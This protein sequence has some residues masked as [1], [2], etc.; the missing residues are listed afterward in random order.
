MG[1]GLYT[2]VQAVV[3]NAFGLKIT[4]ILNTATRTDKV[5]NASPTAAS[6]A[7]DMNGMAAMNACEQMK[8]R[9]TSFAKQDLGWTDPLVFSHGMVSSR[10]NPEQSLPFP[11]F[12][13]KAYMAR[14]SLSEKGFYST[15]DIRV[16]KDAGIGNPFYYFANG[17]SVS[18]VLV[19]THL[20]LIH[21]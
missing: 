15:P 10:E 2:K 8:T 1:Q 7:A 21:I 16:D 3:A 12:V 19:D 11:E 5:P 13:R 14:V 18:E 20:S 9:L 6:S 17:A 4:Q